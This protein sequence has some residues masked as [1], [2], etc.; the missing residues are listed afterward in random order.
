MVFWIFGYGSL[1]WNPGFDYDEKLIG[2]I[3][4]YRRVFDLACIDH[5]GTPE[6]PARTCTLDES[7]GAICWG[8]AYCVRGGPEKEK[9]AMEYLERR[10][11]EYDSKTLVDFFTE[12]DSLR[13]AL[14]GVI[15][16]TSTPDKVN[17]KYYLGPAPLE[18]MARQI[19]T[20]SGP[21]GDNREYIFKME[22]ALYDIGHEDDYIIELANEVR[23]VLGI[24][25]SFPKEKKLL[26]PSQ[27][28]L[29]SHISPVKIRPLPEAIAAVAADS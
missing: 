7:K 27:I 19:A 8:A 28:P 9:K 29:N 13:P 11:C 15:V 18:D 16:F 4:D 20:A 24:V 3:K 23:K 21:C 5:R 22:K 6:H 25:G 1:V 17:N 26:G 2:Y 10:E 14:T 12:E